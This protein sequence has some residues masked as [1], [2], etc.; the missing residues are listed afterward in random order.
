MHASAG[1]R[2]APA[3]LLHRYE[4]AEHELAPLLAIKQAAT[5]P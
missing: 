4:K 5:T 3:S 1:A 2:S